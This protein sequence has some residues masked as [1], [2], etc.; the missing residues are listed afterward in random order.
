M[1][2]VCWRRL[3]FL[4]SLVVAAVAVD[5]I[6]VCAQCAVLNILKK[7]AMRSRNTMSFFSFFFKTS[8]YLQCVI[9]LLLL[10]VNGRRELDICAVSRLFVPSRYLA[11]PP[12]RPPPPPRSLLS[13]HYRHH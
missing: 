7:S 13:V 3:S 8:F 11:P 4:V 5:S 9:D 10:L 1:C 12:F 2:F 6:G